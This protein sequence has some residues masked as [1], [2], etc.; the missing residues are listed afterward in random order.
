MRTMLLVIFSLIEV[1]ATDLTFTTFHLS[2]IPV[3]FPPLLELD[4]MFP[5]FDIC[6]TDELNDCQDFSKEID[7]EKLGKCVI[8][9]FDLCLSISRHPSD[10]HYQAAKQCLLPCNEPKIKLAF[11][12]GICLFVC[13]RRHI[14]RSFGNGFRIGSLSLS[15]SDVHVQKQYICV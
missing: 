4:S 13:Y 10:L 1:Q 2:S 5:K 15:L 9:S 14:L 7:L 11:H 6:Y 8:Y 12:E 3:T